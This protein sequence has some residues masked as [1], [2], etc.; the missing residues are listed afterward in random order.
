MTKPTKPRPGKNIEF[1]FPTFKL[2]DNNFATFLISINT[3]SDS[4][5]KNSSILS[6]CMINIVYSLFL[7]L[8]II[9]R[10]AI[11]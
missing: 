7:H 9:F 6:F 10:R 11:M 5:L 8:Y 2:K 4:S 1:H 3:I